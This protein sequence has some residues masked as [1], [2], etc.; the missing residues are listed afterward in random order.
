MDIA[1]GTYIFRREMN[2]NNKD[3]F[4]S[5]FAVYD[6]TGAEL[7][8]VNDVAAPVYKAITT[9][10]FATKNADKAVYFDNYALVLTGTATDFELY[11]ERTGMPVASENIE[12]LRD[13]STAYRLSW[14]NATA[15]EETATVMA[16]IYNGTTLVE[17]KVIKEVKMAPGYDGV[18]TGIV[19]VAEGQSVKVY[20][21]T[22]IKKAE[23]PSTQPTEPTNPTNPTDPT[24]PT[25]GDKDDKGGL[26]IGLIAVIV[27]AVVAVA[28]VVVVLVVTKKPK[29]KK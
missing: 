5:N 22:T 11:D 27:A 24:E 10:A 9:I 26:S 13:R 3:A 25:T 1:P 6:A 20:L 15:Q 17:E 16:A 2:M 29:T 8:R 28:G 12:A 23:D 4:R 19:D 14:L 21:K 7:K 18:E